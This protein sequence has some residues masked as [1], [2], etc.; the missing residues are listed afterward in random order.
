MNVSREQFTKIVATVGPACKEYEQLLDLVNA[1]VDV[2]RLNFSHGT[3]EDHLKVIKHVLYINDKY[4]THISLLADLQGPK[5]R[6]GKMEGGGIKIAP[7][8]ELVFTNEEC[9]GT[10]SYTHLTLP[11]KRIV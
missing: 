11:T 7:G 9:I 5:L 1:G 10:V 4:N 3:H 2:F 6:V 8:D